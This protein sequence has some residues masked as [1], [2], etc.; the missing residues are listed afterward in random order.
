MN[1]G[2]YSYS[3]ECRNKNYTTGCCIKGVY[4]KEEQCWT[5]L[6]SMTVVLTAFFVV[7]LLC[8]LSVSILLCC[9]CCRKCKR[10]CAKKTP[11][12]TQQRAPTM[13]APIVP[14]AVVQQPA[15][16]KKCTCPHK[17]SETLSS[18]KSSSNDFN[19]QPPRFT[20]AP[21]KPQV[22]QI[23]NNYPK[24]EDVNPYPKFEMVP[25]KTQ[26][27]QVKKVFSRVQNNTQTYDINNMRVQ[28]QEYDINQY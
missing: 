14:A 18:L 11:V 1:R 13:Y 19:Y 26:A 17:R 5:T 2:Y 12:Q 20:Q 9:V 6:L 25:Q 15:Q 23:E 10:S 3:D 24:F 21:P 7:T 8:V 16:P 28:T 4:Y 27:P 22:Q